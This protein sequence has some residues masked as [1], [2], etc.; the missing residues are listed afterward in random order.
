MYKVEARPWPTIIQH[1]RSL[2]EADP[3]RS[4]MPMLELVEQIAAADFALNL[5]AITSMHQLCIS[6]LP[7][8]VLKEEVLTIDWEP[9]DGKFWFEYWETWS[10]LYKR[11]KKTCLPDQAFPSFVRFLKLKKWFALL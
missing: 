8:F 10:P 11:W 7:E 5:Y 3:A 6:Y 1:Y 9:L 4:F 2:V